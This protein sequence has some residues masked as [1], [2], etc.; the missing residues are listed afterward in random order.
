M[1]SLGFVSLSQR[2]PAGISAALPS[3]AHEWTDDRLDGQYNSLA[4]VSFFYPRASRGGGPS[5]LGGAAAGGAFS[6][7]PARCSVEWFLAPKTHGARALF[8]GDSGRFPGDD[9]FS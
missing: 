2:R 4:V 7:F 6:Y 9:L 5:V 1:G 8:N 3:S